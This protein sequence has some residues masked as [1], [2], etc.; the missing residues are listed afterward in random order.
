MDNVKEYNTRWPADFNVIEIPGIGGYIGM[1]GMPGQSTDILSPTQETVDLD[2]QLARI[3]EWG[4]T[5]LLSLVQEFEYSA[6]D[7]HERI[8][9]GMK[10]IKLPMADRGIPNKAWEASWK[11]VG[12]EVHSILREGGKICIHCVGGHGRTGT[13]AVRILVELGMKTLDAIK[14]VRS[15]RPR[16]IES[17]QQWKYINTLDNFAEE[18]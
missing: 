13:I 9:E 4:A 3:K 2:S 6:A 17:E 8:P 15:V 11:S 18:K 7:F 10:H 1:T 14:L 16:C 12:P 5:L